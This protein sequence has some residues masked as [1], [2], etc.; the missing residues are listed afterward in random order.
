MLG[1]FSGWQFFTHVV[2]GIIVQMK[3][4]HMKQEGDAG[5]SGPGL[6]APA[7]PFAFADSN[8]FTVIVALWVS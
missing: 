4:V 3:H 8:P 5:K 7:L 1:D 6:P 2:T